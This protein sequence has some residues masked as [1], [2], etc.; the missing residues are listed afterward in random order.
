MILVF[1]LFWFDVCVGNEIVW[2]VFRWCALRF[3]VGAFDVLVSVCWW[4]WFL[5]VGIL[6]SELV[7]FDCLCFCVLFVYVLTVLSLRAFA[8]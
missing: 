6:L 8:C 2:F 1:D 5:I 7:C 3:C 4:F